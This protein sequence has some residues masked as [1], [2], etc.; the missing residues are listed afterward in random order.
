MRAWIFFVYC[1]NF[2]DN[3]LDVILIHVT[4]PTINSIPCT[5]LWDYTL[6]NPARNAIHCAA[7]TCKDYFPWCRTR[8]CLLNSGLARTFLTTCFF[9]FIIK[10][11]IDCISLSITSSVS[12]IMYNGTNE[13]N[14][15]YNNYF[16]S[17][18]FGQRWKALFHQ[19]N[20]I[21]FHKPGP[22][23]PNNYFFHF[24]WPRVESHFS[25]EKFNHFS[26][27]RAELPN[28]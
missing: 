8:N 11:R 15:S 27:A 17:F 19:K 24:F 21:I 16:V 12:A 28:N 20:S 9:P 3:T 2:K 1:V 6:V 22:K 23:L 13:T 4:G 26:Q 5:P 14:H 10:K 25:P 7:H 18:F